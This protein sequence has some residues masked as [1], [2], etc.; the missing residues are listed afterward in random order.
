MST[1]CFNFKFVKVYNKCIIFQNNN[2]WEYIKKKKLTEPTLFGTFDT[3]I[4]FN[5]T[6]P[7]QNIKFKIGRL[8]TKRFCNFA[9]QVDILNIFLFSSAVFSSMLAWQSSVAF[10]MPSW[11]FSKAAFKLRNIS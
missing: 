2:L 9:N 4:N 8:F 1:S 7:F 5:L 3:S 6:I 11:Y 10:S